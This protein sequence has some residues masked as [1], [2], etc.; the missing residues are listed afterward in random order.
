M[1]DIHLKIKVAWRVLSGVLQLRDI[2]LPVI[3]CGKRFG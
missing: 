3:F 1:V 2:E